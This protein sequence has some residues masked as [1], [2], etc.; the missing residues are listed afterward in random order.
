MAELITEN[1]FWDEP[2]ETMP[3]PDRQALQVERLRQTVE[4][5]S[6]VP[7]YKA[8]LA[9]AGVTPGDIKSL[10]DLRRLPLTNK[11]DLREHYPVG[12]LA[13]GREDVARFHGSSGTTGKPTFVAYT[14]DDLV[15]WSNLCARI[16]VRGGLRPEHTVQIA[17]GYGLFTG[18]FGLHYGVERVGAAV[19]P[20]ASG[21]T[22]RQIMLL[23][24]L[25]ADVLICT[26]SYALN[27]GEVVK[28]NNLMVGVR[29]EDLSISL[30]RID[31]GIWGKSSVT[32]TLGSDSYLQVD[33]SEGLVSVR[34][35]PDEK[36][37]EDKPLWLVAPKE[38]LHL[39]DKST[40]GRIS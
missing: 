32:E 26:P 6:S 35:K 25:G 17:F 3:I 7:F 11:A 22:Q 38:K 21:N 28:D 24:D 8:A 15:T 33:T 31:A 9:R 14:A 29:P 20:A 4:C 39:F 12:F 36:I 10:D 23:Q 5:V 37:A 34:L 2:A 13:V 19:V 27:V 30:C 1:R 18:G 40:G 16:L